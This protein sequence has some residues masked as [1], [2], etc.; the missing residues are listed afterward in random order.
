MKRSF[1]T[2][3][4]ATFLV[5]V[6]LCMLFLDL[7]CGVF[8]R[9][10][11]I[12]DTKKAMISYSEEIETDMLGGS[13]NIGSILRSM[14]DSYAIT[15]SAVDAEANVFFSYRHFIDAEIKASYKN[16]MALYE[17]HISFHEDEE[18]YFEQSKGADGTVEKLIFVTRT[19]QGVYII[20]TKEIKGIDQD[21]RV[22]TA[23]L[24][25]M[26]VIIVAIGTVA[27]GYATRPFT[28][29]IEKMSRIT[30]KMAKLNFEEKINY[31]SDDEIG[32][33]AKSIDRMSEEL[34]ESIANLKED[35][36][37]R[38]CTLRDLAHEIKTPITTIRGY[39]ENIQYFCE[40]DEKVQRYCNIM[41]DECDEVIALIN[42]MLMMSLLES[43]EY[44]RQYKK[45]S[46][47]RLSHEILIRIGN[48]FADENIKVSMENA[49]LMCNADLI[50]RAVLNF[51]SNAVKYGE[52]GGE[53]VL[54]GTR[55]ADRYVFA[56]TN[57]GASITDEDK[58]KIWEAFYKIDKAR[59]RGEGHGLGLSIVS[60]IAKSHGGDV[61]L[62]SENGKNTF[63]MWVPV[64]PEI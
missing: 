53:I 41:L 40:G 61:D 33:L 32:V 16:W 58:N 63:I 59:K 6:L 49:E 31:S 54:T 45:I 37:K 57:S 13:R 36:E 43:D 25:G 34:K 24:L 11:F 22:V 42:E 1:R 9:Y 38:K 26:S 60:R 17:N 51:V 14:N 23:L 28:T 27:W 62:K 39:T 35:L 50:E 29:Q 55:E 12:Y 64:N 20:M 18:Y 47:S 46:T 44:I 15:G 56:V 21:I 7:M 5:S 8:L 2:K 3:L 30:D 48:E 4:I 10:I 52:K 19:E